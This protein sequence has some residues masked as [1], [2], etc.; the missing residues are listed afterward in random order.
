MVIDGDM[1]PNPIDEGVLDWM[2]SIRGDALTTAMRVVTTVGNTASMWAI[3]IAGFLYLLLR[4]RQPEWALYCGLTQLFGLAL[5][6]VLKNVFGRERPPI[7]P[8]LVVISS[9]SFP[10]GHA[11]NSMVVLGTFAVA[12]CALTGRR[13]PLVAALLGTAAIGLSRVYLAAHWMLD[14]VAGWAIGAAVIALGLLV[15]R[16]RR[17]RAALPD[18]RAGPPAA[19]G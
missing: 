13:W 18:P 16:L 3:G 5:M 19:A 6:V 12:A 7:P 17:G 10:S 11:L 2:L 14:V 4:R 1:W 15:L 8:R 9:E